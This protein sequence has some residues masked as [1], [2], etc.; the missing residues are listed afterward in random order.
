MIYCIL[1]GPGNF[2]C[3]QIEHMII[4]EICL[5]KYNIVYNLGF[6]S[7]VKWF[8]LH[9]NC[10][11]WCHKEFQHANIQLGP[12]NN[13]LSAVCCPILLPWG[14]ALWQ[15]DDWASSLPK[16][17]VYTHMH[18]YVYLYL[19]LRMQIFAYIEHLSASPALHTHCNCRQALVTVVRQTSLF[20]DTTAI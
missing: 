10:M 12:N 4:A 1:S 16:S 2:S 8:L 3:E 15:A 19:V 6:L 7:S 14:I 13:P 18:L 11:C 20:W 17:F 5:S 9:C